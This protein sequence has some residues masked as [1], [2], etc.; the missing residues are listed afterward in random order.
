MIELKDTVALMTS[1]DYK[2][3]FEAEYEQLDTRRI[4][5]AR[6]IEKYKAGKLDYTPACPVEL[7]VRQLK[8]MSEYLQ[9]L[10]LRA[11]I[12]GIEV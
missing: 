7:L 8:A 4:K 5:L 2:D 1:D 10:K 11:E 12:E 9:C 3:R 6:M